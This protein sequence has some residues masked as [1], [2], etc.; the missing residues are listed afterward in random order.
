MNVVKKYYLEVERNYI[1]TVRHAE[2]YLKCYKEGKISDEQFET[3]EK[4]LNVIKNDYEKLAYVMFL[5]NQPQRKEK[6]NKYNQQN[7]LLIDGF[8]RLNTDKKSIMTVHS[9]ILERFKEELPKLLK[10]KDN[11]YSCYW[12]NRLYRFTYLCRVN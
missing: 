2:E 4:N 8:A 10:E 12:R 9:Y 5:F 6:V 1:E 11:E 7:K 3:F